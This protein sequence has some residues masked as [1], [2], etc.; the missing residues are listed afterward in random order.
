MNI[1]QNPVR[2]EYLSEL[3]CRKAVAEICCARIRIS[4]GLQRQ[5]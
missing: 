3:S 5:E 1:K 4:V 2:A